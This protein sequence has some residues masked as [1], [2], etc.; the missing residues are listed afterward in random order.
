MRLYTNFL[1]LSILTKDTTDD[2]EQKNSLLLRYPVEVQEI[3]INLKSLT[4]VSLVSMGTD[5]SY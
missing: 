5:H 3:S 2:N 4:H 1:S